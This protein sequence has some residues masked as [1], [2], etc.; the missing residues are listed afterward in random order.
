MVLV[1]SIAATVLLFGFSYLWSPFLFRYFTEHQALEFTWTLAPMV[2]LFLLALPSLRL[3][4]LLDEV[5]SPRCS[6]GI[7]ASQWYWSYEDLD[8]RVPKFGSYLQSGPLRL[9][10]ADASLELFTGLGLRLLLTSSDVLHS[11]TIPAFGLK[12]DCVPGRLNSLITVL[13]RTGLY[14]G[15][16]SEIC[17]SNHSFIPIAARVL[18]LPTR[19]TFR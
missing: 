13:D 17:G 10:E 6:Y 18:R 12:V 16:C 7:T 14:Y 19:A 8:D 15:Q 3:L 11:F 9:L 1:L 5:G 2:L 4:Y